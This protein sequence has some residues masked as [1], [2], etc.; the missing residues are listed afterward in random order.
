M[1]YEVI[2]KQATKDFPDD[3]QVQTALAEALFES[4]QFAEAKEVMTAVLA[5]NPG[6]GSANLLK[7][8]F[9]LKET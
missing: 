9:L 5:G 2:T 7:A 1:L 4:R 8:R 6:N 3:T